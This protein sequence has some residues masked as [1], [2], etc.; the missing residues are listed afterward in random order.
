MYEFQLYLKRDSLSLAGY[1]YPPL[2]QNLRL[3]AMHLDS[4]LG[5]RHLLQPNIHRS[6]VAV[7]ATIARIANL[8][9]LSVMRKGFE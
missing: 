1:F 9:L 6:T 7:A 8:K 2:Q 4:R 3:N 5:R